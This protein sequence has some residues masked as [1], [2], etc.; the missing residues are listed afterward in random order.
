M[1]ALILAPW[2]PLAVHA[3]ALNVIDII[4]N[5]LSAETSQDSEPSLAVNPVLPQYMI[6]GSFGASQGAY[7]AT[8]NGGATWGNFCQIPSLDK[9]RAW[10][11]GGNRAFAARPIDAE[12]GNPSTPRQ[13]NDIGPSFGDPIH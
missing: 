9:S 7:F 12:S 5:S 10:S 11:A 8:S 13:P 3:G 2:A 6:A 1:L 4:P